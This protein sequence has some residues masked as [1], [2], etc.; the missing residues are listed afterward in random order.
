MGGKT[1]GIKR[2]NIAY[3]KLIYSEFIK[4]HKF[5]N[6]D[7]KT[8]SSKMIYKTVADFKFGDKIMFKDCSNTENQNLIDLLNVKMLP[9]KLRDRMWLAA[10]DRL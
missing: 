3:Y 5:L 6:L 1:K 8:I 4:K 10:L 2:R 9:A 7:W